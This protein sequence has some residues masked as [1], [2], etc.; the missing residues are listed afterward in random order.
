MS[1]LEDKIRKNNIELNN[2]VFDTSI[3]GY[4]IDSSKGDYTLIALVKEYLG[5]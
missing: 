3:A 5:I 1:F 4:I 2:L